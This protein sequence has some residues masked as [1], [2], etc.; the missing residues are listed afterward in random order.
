MDIQHTSISSDD[1]LWAV[2]NVPWLEDR[3]PETPIDAFKSDILYLIYN[4]F[5]WIAARNITFQDGQEPP[6]TVPVTLTDHYFMIFRLVDPMEKTT[7]IVQGISG[8]GMVT[9]SPGTPGFIPPDSLTM[10]VLE[11]QIE[12]TLVDKTDR[13]YV[14]LQIGTDRERVA[15]LTMYMVAKPEEFY[16]AIQQQF[17]V[18]GKL[19]VV[20]SEGNTI[21]S[22]E[23]PGSGDAPKVTM[24][25]AKGHTVYHESRKDSSQVIAKMLEDDPPPPPPPFS[26][27]VG[28]GNYVIN[29]DGSITIIDDNS[30]VKMY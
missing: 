21:S 6:Q 5:D 22:T 25:T 1:H 7:N 18:N 20:D 9:I 17:A 12:V 19:V 29:P 24:Q 10:P 26:C 23:V 2:S 11:G 15:L 3:H 13:C 28:I 30:V 4:P 27:A 16:L 8:T 14:H